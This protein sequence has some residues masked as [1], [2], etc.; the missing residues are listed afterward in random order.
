MSDQCCN[1]PIDVANEF[2]DDKNAEMLATVVEHLRL[3]P[4]SAFANVQLGHSI[5]GKAI[6]QVKAEQA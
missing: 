2:H 5:L 4:P 3:L 1:D 6:D